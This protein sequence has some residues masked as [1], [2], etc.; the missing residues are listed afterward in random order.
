[1]GLVQMYGSIDHLYGHMPEIVTAPET[2]AKPNVVKKL[3]EGAA[4]VL[5]LMESGARLKDAAREVA[6]HTGL[7]KNELYAAALE[8]RREAEEN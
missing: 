2:P 3:E 5:A 1:M 8:G 6:G 4:Q 7:S